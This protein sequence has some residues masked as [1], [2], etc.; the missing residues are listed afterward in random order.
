M[1]YFFFFTILSYVVLFFGLS[2]K[3]P[4]IVNTM[5]TVCKTS[6][7]LATKESRLVCTCVNKDDFTV[8][9]SGDDRQL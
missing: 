1:F 2:G 3:S 4:A 7:N 5:R 8:L 6:Y 9:V